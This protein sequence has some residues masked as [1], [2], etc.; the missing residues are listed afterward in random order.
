MEEAVEAGVA[1]GDRR[2]RGQP[3]EAARDAVSRSGR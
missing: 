3:D 2:G 1:D